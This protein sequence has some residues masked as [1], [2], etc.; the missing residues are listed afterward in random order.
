MELLN[1]PLF[2]IGPATI[3]ELKQLIK[4]KQMLFYVLFSIAYSEIC[5][6]GS[7]CAKGSLGDIFSTY[8]NN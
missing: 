6:S 8:C 1:D 5:S 4:T 2:A 3:K 7:I